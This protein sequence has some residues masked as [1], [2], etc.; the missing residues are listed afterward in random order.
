MEKIF[1]SHVSDKWL[2]SKIFKELIQ[3]KSPKA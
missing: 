2:I 1:V 3:L